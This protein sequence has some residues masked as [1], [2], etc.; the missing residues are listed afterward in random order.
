MTKP[1]PVVARYRELLAEVIEPAAAAVLTLAETLAAAPAADALLS[2]DQAAK[3]LSV[4]P[5]TVRILIGSGKLGAIRVGAGRGAIRI[6]P[7]DIDA[8]EREAPPAGELQDE[9]VSMETIR[10]L[11]KPKRKKREPGGW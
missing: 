9:P 11:A 6:R 5:S 4:R 3:R 10:E 1:S 7:Q 2:V 8:F